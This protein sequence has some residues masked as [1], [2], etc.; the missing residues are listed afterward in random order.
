MAFG[1]AFAWRWT[2]RENEF[3]C[4]SAFAMELTKRPVLATKAMLNVLTVAIPLRHLPHAKTAARR[5]PKLNPDPLPDP[6]LGMPVTLEAL[7]QS[8]VQLPGRLSLEHVCIDQVQQRHE[9]TM[10]IEVHGRGNEFCRNLC[11]IVYGRTKPDRSDTPEPVTINLNHDPIVLSSDLD[12]SHALSPSMQRKGGSSSA[13][14]ARI[15]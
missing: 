15:C 7:L 2:D 4:L 12:V 10:N 8:L 13:P 6:S 9:A 1:S 5:R 3:H 14:N 11:D